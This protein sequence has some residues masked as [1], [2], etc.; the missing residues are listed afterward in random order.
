MAPSRRGRR[1]CAVRTDRT[2][3]GC[4][5]LSRCA[6]APRSPCGI[7][8]PPGQPHPPPATAVAPRAARL[9]QDPKRGSGQQRRQRRGPVRAGPAGQDGERVTGWGDRR[10]W[11]QEG[12]GGRPGGEGARSP[13]GAKSRPAGAR[14]PLQ[15]GPGAPARGEPRAPR[16]PLPGASQPP[17]PRSALPPQADSRDGVG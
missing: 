5:G 7:G 13:R 17:W 12:S 1:R 4:S 14:S 3:A 9:R 2:G 15:D 11:R 6:P 16:R 8:A 10:S